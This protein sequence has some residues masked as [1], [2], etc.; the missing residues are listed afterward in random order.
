MSY[1]HGVYNSEIDTSL[2]GAHSGQRGP[3]GDFRHR[4]HSPVQRSGG[5]GK[6]AH[7]VLLFRGVP[8]ECGV[9]RQLQGLYPVPEH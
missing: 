9:F 8:A 2:T 4:P 5:G 1:F 7:A 3:A 6:Q